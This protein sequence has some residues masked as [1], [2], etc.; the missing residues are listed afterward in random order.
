MSVTTWPP[1]RWCIIAPNHSPV[2]C[3]S[4]A[5]V[6]DTERPDRCDGSPPRAVPAGRPTRATGSPI[7]LKPSV[8][9][10]AGDPADVV[11]HALR[12][13]GRATRV[14]HVDVVLGAFDPRHRVGAGDHVV[15]RQST[16]DVVLASVV[17]LDQQLQFGEPVDD[18]ADTIGERRVVHQRLGVG[19]VEQVPQLVVE[20]AVVDVDGHAAHLERPVL[21]L[22]VLVAVVQV[23]PDLRIGSEAG[24]GDRR[25]RPAPPVRRIPTTCG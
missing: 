1:A 8:Q 7:P 11:H 3:I 25:R 5:P 21:G 24:G 2:P 6:I 17:D 16:V 23:E 13:A 10:I 20:V 14:Q 22:E 18:P 4:G 12:H 9:K 19:V 15:V